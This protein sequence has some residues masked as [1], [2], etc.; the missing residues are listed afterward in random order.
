[1]K[2]PSHPLLADESPEDTQVQR[3][4]A[5]SELTDL[6]AASEGAA[7]AMGG[8][9]DATEDHI[10]PPQPA[11]DFDEPTPIVGMTVRREP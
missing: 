6:K 3:R 2:S 1:M 7:H 4:T 10:L 8:F 9:D 5:S 11:D